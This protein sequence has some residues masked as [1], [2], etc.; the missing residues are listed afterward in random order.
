MRK[1]ALRAKGLWSVLVLAGILGVIGP[2]AHGAAIPDLESRYGEARRQYQGLLSRLKDSQGQ[3]LFRKNIERFQEI[4]RQDVKQQLADRCLFMIARSYHHLH[5]ALRAEQDYKKALAYYKQV[6]LRFPQSPLA[7]DALFLSGILLEAREPS[8]AYLE[9]LRVCVLFPQGDMTTRAR[10][11]AKAL[12][13]RLSGTASAGP[14]AQSVVAED[15][16]EEPK[17]NEESPDKGFKAAS[18]ASAAPLSPQEP[19]VS[20]EKIRHWSADEY[21]RVVIYLSGPV[22]YGR[23]ERPAD[24]E[25]NLPQ[26]IVLELK[27]CVVGPDVNSTVP[28]MDGLLQGVRLKA[29]SEDKTQV[30]LDLQSVE[31]YRVF[32]LADPFRVVI[33][34]KGQKKRPS[35]VVAPPSPTSAAPPAVQAKPILKKGMPSVIEQLGLT[36]RR[37]VIDPGHGGKDKGAIGPGGVYEKDITLAV[38]KE[39]K[40]ILEKEGGYEVILTRNTDRYLSL[41]ERTAIA[42][43]KKADLFISIHTNAHEDRNLGGIETYFLNFSKDK[44]SARLAALENATSAKHISDLEAILNELLHNTKINESSRLAREIHQGM[45]RSLK[46]HRNLRD[47]GVKQAPFYVLLGAQMPSVLIE[48]CFISNPQEEQLLKQAQFQ[49]ALAKA[50]SKGIRSYRDRLAQVSRLGEGA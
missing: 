38:A 45:M 30:I 9:F 19:R 46:A 5:D 26:R 28:I 17:A 48:A 42:N 39:L 10:Q 47:L 18:S 33:D 44:E 35:Q 14:I 15:S 36:V 7:D 34:V 21:T 2:L 8:E 1:W 23:S 11:K 22:R 27:R 43:T 4:L 13:K 20:V 31:F 40:K 6:A 37:I 41:E 49:R 29:S 3:A 50:I 12:A 32:S 25:R 16:K 24:P